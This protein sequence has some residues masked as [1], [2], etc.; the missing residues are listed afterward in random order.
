[1]VFTYLLAPILDNLF[2]KIKPEIKRCICIVLVGLYLVDFIYTSQVKPNT[3]AGI[4]KP[5]LEVKH[6][7]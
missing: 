5:V 1:M 4:S 6:E 7:I 3:G 2:N